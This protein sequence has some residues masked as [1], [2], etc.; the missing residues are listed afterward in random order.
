VPK[1]L[2]INDIH[3]IRRCVKSLQFLLIVG[4][5]EKDTSKKERVLI[6]LNKRFEVLNELQNLEVRLKRNN[7]GRRKVYYYD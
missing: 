2:K 1:N 4:E 7:R 3:E 6:S 5:M